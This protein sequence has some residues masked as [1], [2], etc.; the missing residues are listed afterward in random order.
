MKTKKEPLMKKFIIFMFISFIMF[1]CAKTDNSKVLATIDDEKIT[2]NEFN[3]ELDKIPINM[4]MMVATQTGKKNYLE[5][6]IMKKLL[7]KEAKKENIEKE[8]D[9]QE[10]LKEI[11]EQLLIESL[12]KKKINVDAQITEA[13]LKEYYEKNKES[14]K[15]EREINTRHILLNTA[16]EARQIK[17]K[18]AKGEDFAEL[19]KRYSIDPSAKANGG[20]IGFHP[21]GTLLPEYEAAAFKLTKVGQVSDIVKTKFGYHIIKLEGIRP[22]SYVPFEE[23]K[24]FIKQKIAQEKQTQALEK[25]ITNLKSTAKITINEDLLKDEAQ[26]TTEKNEKVEVREKTPQSE[27]KK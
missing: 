1:G 2:I 23:V 18:I 3:K 20:E 16:E 21:K 24:D 25:Y 4:K 9:F 10:R 5:K 12:L 7:L 27:P 19:A 13:D 8:A 6:I 15:R 11:K 26:K 14:F 22:P 17:E